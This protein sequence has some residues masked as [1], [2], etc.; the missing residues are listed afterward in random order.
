M[1]ATA[2]ALRLARAG[3]GICAALTLVAGPATAIGGTSQGPISSQTPYVV[4]L[5]D[6]VETRSILTVGDDVGGYRLVGIPDGL[7][8]LGS[9]DGAFRLFMNH[10]LPA[11]AGIGRAH[12]GTG[13]AIVSDYTV[14]AATLEV[15]N[16]ADLDDEAWFWNDVDAAYEQRTGSDANFNR[17]CSA[18]L[19]A[20]SAFW[21][22]QTRTGYNGRLFMDGEEAAEGR[23]FAHAV[24]G[25]EHGTAWE[26]PA[27]GRFAW[28]NALAAPGA[29]HA[30][31]VVGTDDVN[32]RGEV[33]V[34]VGTKQRDGTPIERAGL[35][36]GAL[37][38]IKVAGVANESRDLGINAPSREF[39][40]HRFGDVTGWSALDLQAAS[41]ANAVT[42]FLRPEDGAWD[43]M[44]PNDF[45]FAT[46]DRFNMTVVGNSRLW[47]LRFHD[48]THPA[49]GGTISAV[50]EGTEP[51]QSMDNIAIDRTGHILIQEDPGV[52]EHLSKIWSYSIADDTLTAIAEADPARFATGGSDF[53]TIDEESS[54]IVDASEV[55]GP[56]WFIAT[57]QADVPLADPELVEAG[58]VFAL[59]NPASDPAP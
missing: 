9:D 17:F 36:G 34:Y 29:G 4:P 14:D 21:D 32:P 51:P 56:G 10:E 8:V 30:T 52:R 46:T 57:V 2:T 1:G 11:D 16:G 59:Y 7:G 24:T 58:Q 43:P 39:S 40:L 12:G 5:A 48:V 18:D 6:G 3:A 26:L 22:P 47:R 45:Y 55:L 15:R 25:R 35:T 50:V 38:G 37:Y 49:A 41:S 42:T 13:G 53:M 31:V 54:G 33:Y 44:H 20:K 23:A 19:A 28:E 27:L